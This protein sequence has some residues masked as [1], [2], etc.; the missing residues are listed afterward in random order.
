MNELKSLSRI[1]LEVAYGVLDKLYAKCETTLKLIPP[2]P[3]HGA[4]CHSYYREWLAFHAVPK[5]ADAVVREL[6]DE[7]KKQDKKLEAIR[8]LV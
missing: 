8:E 6:R 2:C 4:M 1:E 5:C 3:D 7:L